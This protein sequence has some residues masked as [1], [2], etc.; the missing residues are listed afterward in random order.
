[1]VVHKNN[2]K[3]RKFREARE[4]KLYLQYVCNKQRQ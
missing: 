3:D 4:T 1:M 2:F